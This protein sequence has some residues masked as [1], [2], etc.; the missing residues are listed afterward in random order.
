MTREAAW[1]GTAAV[2]RAPRRR[3]TAV[4][5]TATLPIVRLHRRSRRVPPPEGCA[6]RPRLAADARFARQRG[7]GHEKDEPCILRPCRA[8]QYNFPM[9]TLDTGEGVWRRPRRRARCITTTR[10]GTDLYCHP[11]PPRHCGRGKVVAAAGV[12]PA[13]FRRRGVELPRLAA[14]AVHGVTAG[15]AAHPWTLWSQQERKHKPLPQELLISHRRGGWR[16]GFAVKTSACPPGR[17]AA[18]R[19]VE[20]GASRHWEWEAVGAK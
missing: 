18:R 11:S 17:E 4:A 10:I 15:N 1:P 5:G 14:N 12:D 7:G 13:A 8:H 9:V 19:A 3:A 2:P 16:C 20:A 6:E